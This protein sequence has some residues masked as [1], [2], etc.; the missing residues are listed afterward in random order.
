MDTEERGF[1]PANLEVRQGG[2]SVR[3]SF[4]YGRLATL[5]SRGSVRKE[6]FSPNAFDFAIDDP[7]REIN[8]LVGHDYGQP[9]ASKL[10]GTLE[11]ADTR[12][13][14]V[15]EA[16]LPLESEQPTWMRD[17]VL[18]INS[19]LFRGLSPGFQIPPVTAVRNAEE[20][21]PEPGNPGVMIRQVNKAVLFEFSVVTRP[22]YPDTE[23]AVRSTPIEEVVADDHERYRRWL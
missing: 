17:A 18:S 3:G 4:P 21:L 13:A 7:E 2:R 6:R 20:L 12:A 22:A 14:V 9:L 1:Y 19:G 10:E 5:S 16:F 11:L 8:L 15:F 23:V